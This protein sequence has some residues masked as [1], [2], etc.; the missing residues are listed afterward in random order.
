MTTT[1]SLKAALAQNEGRIAKT[2]GYYLGFI[3]LGFVL[4]AIGPTLQGL[5]DNTGVHLAD[6]GILFTMRALGYTLGSF[7]VGK[8]YDHLAGH[9]VLAVTLVG[10][11]FFLFVI[12]L[13]PLLLV[14]MAVF[15]L[16]GVSEAGL[17]VGGNT[18]IVWVHGEK[19]SPFLNGLHFFFGVGAFLSPIIVAQMI[20][21]TGDVVGAYWVLAVLVLPAAL[22]IIRLPSP[23]NQAQHSNGAADRM[24]YKLVA[25]ITLLLLLYVGAEISFGG[26]IFSYATEL[27]LMTDAAAAFLTSVFWGGLTLGRLLAVPLSARYP[28]DRL[29]VVDF[30]GCL[31]CAALPLMWSTPIIL[32]IS[33]VGMGLA[34][35][36]V[37]PLCIALAERK[38]KITGK[39]TRWF[40]GGVGLGAM[41]MPWIIGRL[42][43]GVGAQVLMWTILIDI[44]IALGALR[45]L[46][47]YA[48]PKPANV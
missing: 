40:F 32:W 4:G 47:A 46:L 7:S 33:A 13:I 9:K 41:T 3:A 44:I 35:A 29:L 8:L 21:I 5:A 38:M 22:W 11:A 48:P 43:E 17:D 45:L 18:L 30:L 26:W 10:I 42:F 15:F 12:P 14:L 2:I 39:V 28:A 6:V 1:T 25:L 24:D 37:F 23:P 34:M 27:D 31:V 16:M 36:S 19:A 20:L